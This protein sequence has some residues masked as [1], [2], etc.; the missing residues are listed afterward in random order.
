MSYRPSR[1]GSYC[2]YGM[3]PACD[4]TMPEARLP[5]ALGIRLKVREVTDDD[6]GLDREYLYACLGEVLAERGQKRARGRK[7][8]WEEW[9]EALR[10][11]GDNV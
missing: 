6:L 1:L 2:G 8:T 11:A 7:V 5:R 4:F 3:L 10:R 9:A